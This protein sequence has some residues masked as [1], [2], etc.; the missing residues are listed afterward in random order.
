MKAYRFD[1]KYSEAI[2]MVS[3][4]KSIKVQTTKYIYDVENNMLLQGTSVTLLM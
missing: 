3:I 4:Y 2:K 1:M